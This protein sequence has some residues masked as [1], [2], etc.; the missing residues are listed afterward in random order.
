MKWKRY[1]NYDNSKRLFLSK[2]NESGVIPN[3]FYS[4][5]FFHFVQTLGKVHGAEVVRP[6]PYPPML[7]M[8][9]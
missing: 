6:Y 8:M 9:S 5:L 2:R 3:S 4:Y 7:R 1:I